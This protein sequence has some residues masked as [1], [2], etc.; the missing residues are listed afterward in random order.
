[1]NVL[2]KP[3]AALYV[4][5]LVLPAILFCTSLS[6]TKARGPYYIGP[7]YDPEYAYLLGSLNAAGFHTSNLF[8]HPGTPVQ[9]IGGAV[10]RAHSLNYAGLQTDVLKRPERYLRRLNGFILAANVI[11]L[12]ILGMIAFFLTGDIIPG[13]ILQMTPFLS[14]SPQHSLTR[15]NPEPFLLLAGLMLICAISIKLLKT[16][17]AN[18]D[19][20]GFI[21]AF[22]LIGGFGLAIKI[23]FLPLL[24]IPLFLFKKFSSMVKYGTAALVFFFLLLLPYHHRIAYY[25][26]WL[27]KLTRH[28]GKYGKG[29]AGLFDFSTLLPNIEALFRKE[30]LFMYTLSLSILFILVNLAAPRLRKTA[31][32][33]TIFRALL[34][35]VA[36]N[37]ICLAITLKHF[38]QKYLLVGFSLTGAVIALIY[39]YIKAV[40]N[41]AGI[42]TRWLKSAAAVVLILTGFVSH[43]QMPDTGRIAKQRARKAAVYEKFLDQYRGYKK[44]FYYGSTSKR[45]ALSFGNQIAAFYHSDRLESIYG[46]EACFYNIYKKAF[47]NWHKKI[48]PAEVLKD[49][50]NIV[51]FGPGI[52]AGKQE[53]SINSLIREKL[54]GYSLKPVNAAPQNRD[55]QVFKFVKIKPDESAGETYP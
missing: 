40:T 33:N 8:I 44:I 30:P 50:A 46:N 48:D 26:G 47:F 20:R 41:E 34:G 2:K 15:F 38:A 12:I 22:A 25:F 9:I 1:M 18:G 43:G 35:L 31:L 7:T 53:L 45:F 21:L 42:N 52:T 16:S 51:M 19:S 24:L 5:Y 3:K 23:T 37:T 10:L 13:L 55:E 14:R 17:S 27:W 11:M 49:P 54:P 39:L 6:L 4:L 29:S 32:K 36:A 28:T